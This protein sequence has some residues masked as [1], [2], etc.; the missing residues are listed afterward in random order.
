MAYDFT[1]FPEDESINQEFIE[2]LESRAVTKAEFKRAFTHAFDYVASLGANYPKNYNIRR[3]KIGK[4]EHK[5]QFGNMC[6]EGLYYLANIYIFGELVLLRYNTE[7][8]R[9]SFK[10]HKAKKIKA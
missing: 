5:G 6:G 9:V 10:W 4:G 7:L 3:Y 8:N 1:H 2:L